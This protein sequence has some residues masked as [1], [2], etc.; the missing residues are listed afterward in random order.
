[1]LA[2]AFLCGLLLAIR[3]ADK[4]GIEADK[5]LDI[6]IYVIISAIIG[7]RF[8]YVVQFWSEFKGNLLEVFAIHH[9]GLVFYGGLILALFTLLWRTRVYNLSLIKVIDIATPPTALGYS[10]ARIGCFLNGCCYG[11]E[12]KFPLAVKFPHLP[13]LRHPTQLYASGIMFLAFLFLLFLWKR[14][15]FEGQIFLSG[16]LLYSTYRFFIE[17]IRVGPRYALGLTLS[18]LVSIVIFGIALFV[19]VKR[20][21]AI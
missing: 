4:E 14:R 5:V 16:L 19:L 10:L 7:A 9:G 21:K 11:I 17:F 6:T 2:L 18:Q 15:K 3:L 20:F 8:F 1:M 12:T 13:G